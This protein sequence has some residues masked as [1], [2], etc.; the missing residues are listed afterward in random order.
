MSVGKKSKYT[1][2]LEQL[3]YLDKEI[4]YLRAKGIKESLIKVEEEKA[5]LENYIKNIKEEEKRELFE[6][7]YFK[8][9]KGIFV[10]EA[11]RKMRNRY[12]QKNPLNNIYD[13]KEVKIAKQMILKLVKQQTKN[14]DKQKVKKEFDSH[15]IEKY[16]SELDD[17]RC[18]IILRYYL[19]DNI[20]VSEIGNKVDLARSSVLRMLKNYLCN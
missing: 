18:R 17:S 14:S 15:Q 12:M 11:D 7:A 5:V 6:F 9:K 8:C 10:Y 4:K 2:R 1:N 20:S 19:I 13:A 3:L 16:I